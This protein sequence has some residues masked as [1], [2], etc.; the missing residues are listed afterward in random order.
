M[1]ED[2]WSSRP[3]DVAAGLTPFL[4]SSDFDWLSVL[5]VVRELFATSGSS[6]VSL[7]MDIDAVVLLHQDTHVNLP[8][9]AT[10]EEYVAEL[11][12]LSLQDRDGDGVADK[13]FCLRG[14]GKDHASTLLLYIA[15]SFFQVRGQQ[16]DFRGGATAVSS[17]LCLPGERHI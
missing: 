13:P 17:M 7:P 15:T 1:A 4:S 8:L 2:D 10:W 9:V 3:E 6:V 5:P 11:R 16:V 14:G 12:R